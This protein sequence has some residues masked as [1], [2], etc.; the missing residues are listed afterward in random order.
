MDNLT[1]DE[2]ELVAKVFYDTILFINKQL[3][4]TFSDIHSKNKSESQFILA[5]IQSI[6]INK[7][8]QTLK[9]Q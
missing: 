4:L 9:P 6:V 2:T 3:G 1:K 7:R 5:A 8:V